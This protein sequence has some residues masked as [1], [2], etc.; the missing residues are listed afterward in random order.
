VAERGRL[1]TP[2]RDAQAQLNEFMRERLPG[3][4]S[5]DLTGLLANVRTMSVDLRQINVNP[6]GAQ[7]NWLGGAGLVDRCQSCHVG[8]DP[9]IVPSVMTLTKADLGMADNPNA[10]FASHPNPALLRSHPLDRFGCS[11]CHGG[12]GRALDSVERGHGRYEHWLW[13]LNYPENYEAGCQQCHA[14]DMVTEHASV[15]NQGKEA[16]RQKGCIGCHRFQGFDNEDEL[17]VAA[18][19][20]ILQL[21][22][23]KSTNMVEVATLNRRGDEAPDNAAA[24]RFYQQ[25]TNLTVAI[26][27]TDAEIEQLERRSHDLLQEIKKIGPDLKEIR[28]KLRK[29]W[30]PYW[31]QNTHEFRPTTKMPQ[32]RLQPEEVQ[33]ISAFVWQAAL[34]GPALPR[35]APG[36]AAR[37][38]QLFESR[39]C[40]AC[41]S[42]GEGT[43]RMGGDFA[44]N[45]SRVGEKANYDY[46]VRWVHDPRQRTRPYCSF[47]RRDLGPED[48]ARHGLPFVFDLE[49][50]R[51]PN[52]GHELVVQQPTPMPSFRL[53]DQ[54][55]RDIASYLVTLRR[56]DASY[57][58]AAF[59][60]DTSL[61]DRGRSLVQ[62]YGCA[63]CHEIAT[64][65]EEGRIGTELTNQGSK[66]VDRL[67]FALFTEQA[68]RGILPNGEPSPRGPWYDL[69]GFVEHKLADPAIYDTGKYKPNPADRLRMPKPNITPEEITALTTMLI[70]STDPTLPPDYMYR[71][72][73]N[74]AAIQKGWWLVTKYNC[75]GCHEIGIGQSSTLMGLPMYQGNNRENLP[76]PLTSE[77]ARVNPEWL[78]RFLADPSLANRA[79][80]NGV[81]NYLQ[82]RM[83]TF[84]FSND[85]IRSLVLFFEAISHQPPMYIPPRLEPV[86]PTEMTMSRQLFTSQ[87][88]PCLRCHAT[89]DPAHDA[90]ATAP[91]FLLAPERL[92]PGWTERWIVNPQLID[93]GTA[94]PSGLF[95]REG[96]RWV[97]NGPL[98]ATF[99]NYTGDHA[100]MLVR[101]MLQMTPEEQRTLLGRTP[102][103]GN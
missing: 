68:K 22:N 35:Q 94:M 74:R 15:L 61:R 42:I 5:N 69:K 23:E 31:L 62:F 73:D 28:M 7:I 103:A 32:F 99:Q 59:M 63:G 83:P 84:S 24:N 55:A 1:D 75:M 16:Y 54:D 78:R 34:T 40:L 27:N 76:P 20:R 9:M 56:P 66:V 49:H 95:R 39:G 17:L 82:V 85:E 3:L 86:T 91:N 4:S 80:R 13:P 98:P 8:T 46:L 48:Y 81:R 70:G 29:E 33:A 64:L 44:A 43:S 2:G 12:N 72:A 102:A 47:E 11:P 89:G 41:H 30:V 37:G 26:S 10:P 100:N 67:D 45:L 36:N 77:G 96:E 92:R 52:D 90:T 87:A 6:P 53:S 18:R 50:S 51:C 21:S 58:A 88:A 79:N 19:Q 57:P 60:D 71:P 65:E 14:A 38:Q 97:F 25:A 101:Y 93:P